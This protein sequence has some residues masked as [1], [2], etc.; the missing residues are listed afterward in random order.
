MT[1]GDIAQQYLP[2]SQVSSVEDESCDES[3]CSEELGSQSRSSRVDT[4]QISQET[5]SE[6]AFREMF[7]SG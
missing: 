4:H 7:M 2:A 6:N 1:A 3:D 5:S